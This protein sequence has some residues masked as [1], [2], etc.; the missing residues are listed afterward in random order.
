MLC[1]SCAGDQTADKDHPSDTTQ[2]VGDHSRNIERDGEDD[3]EDGPEM[4]VIDLCHL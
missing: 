3:D 4:I 1:I 2:E